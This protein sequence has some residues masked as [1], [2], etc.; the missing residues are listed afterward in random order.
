M[1]SKREP[2]ENSCVF[3]GFIKAHL[4][5]HLASLLLDILLY[6]ASSVSHSGLISTAL[7]PL[8]FCVFASECIFV[9]RR[10]APVCVT[11]Q[12]ASADCR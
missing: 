4:I 7:H 2:L 10:V 12:K 1:F 8:C 3:T 11:V 6:K 9:F 5:V